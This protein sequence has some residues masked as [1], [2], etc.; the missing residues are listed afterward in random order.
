MYLK[1]RP[2]YLGAQRPCNNWL[3]LSVKARTWAGNW[4]EPTLPCASYSKW[5]PSPT[6]MKGLEGSST[7]TEPPFHLREEL[8]LL[9][10]LE[11]G[12]AGQRKWVAKHTLVKISSRSSPPTKLA[13]MTVSDVLLWHDNFFRWGKFLFRGSTIIIGRDNSQLVNSLAGEI[14]Q[15]WELGW[16]WDKVTET[17]GSIH[18][19]CNSWAPT[20][21]STRSSAAG[22][23]AVSST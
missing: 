13:S 11:T 9:L 18:L 17:W 1:Q 12:K 14:R 10:T 6:S 15:R 22:E 20:M 8:S 7:V 19:L 23:N 5:E 3:W 16:E 4:R 2:A 21:C